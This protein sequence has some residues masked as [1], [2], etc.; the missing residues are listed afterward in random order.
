MC[1]FSEYVAFNKA[2]NGQIDIKHE[3]LAVISSSAFDFFCHVSTDDDS[4]EQD[5]VDQTLN[6]TQ[7]GL[8]DL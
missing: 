3:K 6:W 2:T 7:K 5:R 4:A 8:G 1:G